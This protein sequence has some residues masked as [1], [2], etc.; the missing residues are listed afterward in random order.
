M[1]DNRPMNNDEI[2]IDLV[3]LFVELKKKWRLIAGTTL[4]FAAA[5]AFYSFCI[6]KP[7]YQYNALIRIPTV[8]LNHGYVINTCLELLKNDSAASVTDIR[9]T[10]LIKLSFNA[11]TSDEAKKMAEAY[12]PKATNLV[13]K[14]VTESIDSINSSSFQTTSNDKNKIFGDIKAEVILQDKNLDIPVSP[15]KKKN[16]GISTV[17]GCILSACYVIGKYIFNKK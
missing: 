8:G 1:Q 4:A 10:S 3:E 16:I 9:N 7:V 5:A 13:N 17:F 6:A 14:I 15:N 11:T 2:E 12:L